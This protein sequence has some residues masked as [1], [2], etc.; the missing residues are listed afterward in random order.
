M[1]SIA[2][3]SVCVAR[4]NWR[5]CAGLAFGFVVDVYSGEFADLPPDHRELGLEA[6]LLKRI[7]TQRSGVTSQARRGSRP[8]LFVAVGLSVCGVLC[9][10]QPVPSATSTLRAVV[11]VEAAVDDEVAARE[12]EALELRVR[13][14]GDEGGPT[15]ATLQRLQVLYGWPP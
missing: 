6:E 10:S 9:A 12:L 5:I 3:N 7:W 14:V 13:A 11:A 8:L 2:R 4:P 15:R 1:S